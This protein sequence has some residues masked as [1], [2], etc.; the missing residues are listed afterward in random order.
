MPGTTATTKDRSAEIAPPGLEGLVVAETGIGDVRGLEGFYHFRGY[1]ATELAR[2]RSFE[3]VLELMF[4]GEL[5]VAG[6]RVVPADR[7]L[8]KGLADSLAP[9]ASIGSPL[10]V[11]RSAVSLLGAELGWQP[12]LDISSEELVAQARRLCALV[13][14]ILTSA[15][16]LRRGLQPI[17]PRSDLSLAANYLFMMN[18]VEPEARIARAVEQYLMLVIDHGFNAST[19][20]TR[21]IASTG[22]DLAACICGGIGALSGPLHGGAPSR[23]LDMLDAIGDPA[24]T[25]RFVRSVVT[26]GGRIMGF[27]HRVYKTD[28]PRSVLLHEVARELD[29]P[30]L[31]FASQVESVVEATLAELKPGRELHA[32]VEFYAGVVMDAC[33]IDR[34]MFTPTF[35][36][37][38]MVGWCAHV[39][40]QAANNRLIRPAS[41]YVGPA[42]PREVS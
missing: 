31:S 6:S 37:G 30:L 7:E 17:P 11:L 3:D 18:G 2:K 32:N 34:A 21:V 22:A 14:T 5:P 42:A 13:P 4:S 41:R 33:G 25:E 12:T 1:S 19:F 29:A 10:E 15:D 38:R 35:A 16:R 40:E 28:D 39:I 9:I 36:V 20:T 24:N 8:P 27:G 26:S 23:A